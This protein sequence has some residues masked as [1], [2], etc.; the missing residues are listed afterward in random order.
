MGR[1]AKLLSFVRAVRNGAKL[2]DVKFDPG[3]G[4]NVTG[5]HYADSGDDAQPL[6]GDYV[7]LVRDVGTG[8]ESVLGYLDPKNQQKAGPGDK[9]IYARNSGGTQVVEVWLKSDGS[10]IIQNSTGVFTLQPDGEFNINGARITTSGDLITASGVSLDNHYH[11]Q[12]ADSD[13]D[14]EQPTEP[15][16]ATE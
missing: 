13:G 3:G 8:R 1:I 11:T 5:V 9:R 12:G 15:P 4:P 14:S 7:A 10:A 16:T 6:P 2:S